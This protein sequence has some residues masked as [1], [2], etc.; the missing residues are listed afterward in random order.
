MGV[1]GWFGVVVTRGMAVGML[2]PQISSSLRK[3]H[4]AQTDAKTNTIQLSV[5]ATNSNHLSHFSRLSF[6]VLTIC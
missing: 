6:Y 2:R 5:S 1:G 4:K 3:E